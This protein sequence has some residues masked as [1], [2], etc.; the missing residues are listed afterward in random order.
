[1]L[2]SFDIESLTAASADLNAA[3]DELARAIDRIDAMLKKLNWG[4]MV[5]VERIG[6]FPPDG[7]KMEASI[8]YAKIAGKWG[9]ALAGYK[10]DG[11]AQWLFNDAPRWLRIVMVDQIPLLL[12]HIEFAAKE[13]AG[14]LR[15]KSA[16]VAEWRT[17]E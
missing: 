4:I 16:A 9:L 3:S 11:D 1:M 2:G 15:E 10:D 17:T 14:V 13:L 5:W 7:S 8:G 12:K 6:V